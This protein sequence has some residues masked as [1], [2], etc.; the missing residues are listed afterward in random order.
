MVIDKERGPAKLPV[1]ARG[2]IAVFAGAALV[3]ALPPYSQWWSASLSLSALLLLV[4]GRSPAVAF[5]I[6]CAFGLGFFGVGVSWIGESFQVDAERFGA[7]AVPAVATLSAILATFIGAACAATVMVSPRDGVFRYAAV[8]AMCWAGAEWLRG[9]IL[10]GFPWNLVAYVTADHAPFRQAAAVFGSYGLSAM[11]V[12]LAALPGAVLM[13]RNGRTAMMAVF[14]ALVGV[15]GLWSY[16]TAYLQAPAPSQDALAIRI[17]QG[18]IP[19]ASKWDPAQREAIIERYLSLS[20]A[21]GRFQVLVWPE[22]AFPGFL[23]EDDEVRT[24]IAKLLPVGGFL[25]AGSPV[26]FGEGMKS[27]YQN[28]IVVVRSDGSIADLYAK[29]HLVPFGEY[30]PFKALLPIRRMVESLGDF[31]PGDGPRTLDLGSLRQ[32]A[33]AICYEAIFPGHVVDRR[34]EAS[35]IVNVTNDAWFGTS[36]GPYQHL[37]SAR[38]RAIEEGLPLVRAANT[39]I[40]IVSDAHGGALGKIGLARE[41]IVDISLPASHS[42]TPYATFGDIAALAL[43]GFLALMGALLDRL[44]KVAGKPHRVA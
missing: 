25:L 12:W 6:G 41:G 1:L 38:M 39:G 24:R 33:A 43:A 2:V 21:P 27:I 3:A 4:H 32:P 30:V 20:A 22:A 19:Q 17:V 23:A 44:L 42:P 7:L 28:A 35:W 26:R 15:L 16:G 37:A 9:H 10:T 8:L 36:I 11:V 5:A 13:A 34:S 18:N 29:H 14:A 40:S 31:T